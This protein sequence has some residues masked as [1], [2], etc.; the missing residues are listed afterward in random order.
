M[1]VLVI[2]DHMDGEL[3]PATLNAVTAAG[4]LD[5]EVHVLVAGSG[6]QAIADAAAKIAGVAKVL[7][8]DG[9]GLTHMLAE[10]AAP[11]IAD[12][13]KGYSHVLMTAT[14]TGKNL[15]PRVAALLDSQQISDISAIESADTFKRPIYAGNAI[16]TV[17]SSDAIKVIT[18]RSTAFDAAPAEGGS[19]SIEGVGAGDDKGLA[20]FVGQ[21]LSKSDRP[22][23]SSAGVVISGG[24]GMG[25]GENFS[26]LEPIADTGFVMLCAVF[27]ST[28]ICR[29]EMRSIWHLHGKPV[30]SSI[31]R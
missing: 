13:A 12:L 29:S 18:V 9:S 19:A 2:A 3:K 23:L 8:A 6:S 16:A 26:L 14:T 25:S 5:G 11:V 21:E 17:Q 15:M 20:S 28:K 27:R 31:H 30:A 4:K 22:E 7:H 1:A 24:R 10:N